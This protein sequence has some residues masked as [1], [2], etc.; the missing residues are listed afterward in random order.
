MS[1]L[2][3]TLESE[4]DL[5]QGN[6][7]MLSRGRSGVDQVYSL[8]EGILRLEVDKPTYERMGLN[9]VAIPSQGRKHV[10][11]RYGMSLKCVNLTVPTNGSP[12]N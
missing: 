3:S 7:V 11:A 5:Q 1:I 12:S 8:H 9:G 6:I 2:D 10:K 4:A